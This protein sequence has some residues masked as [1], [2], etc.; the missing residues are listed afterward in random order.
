MPGHEGYPTVRA[1]GMTTRL[2]GRYPSPASSGTPAAHCCIASDD[3]VLND[4]PMRHAAVMVVALVLGCDGNQVAPDA[5][6]DAVIDAPASEFYGEPC[7]PPSTLG[8]VS[9]CR[10]ELP[11]PKAYCTPEGVC[12]RFCEECKALGGIE[13]YA[14]PTSAARVCYCAPPR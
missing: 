5:S 7:S 4:G 8:F 3:E 14:F 2:P 10:P 12:R 9:T 6:I 13:T 1:V 11:F